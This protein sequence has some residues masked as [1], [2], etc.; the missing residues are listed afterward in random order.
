M[1]VGKYKSTPVV[2]LESLRLSASTTV[3]SSCRCWKNRWWKA[4]EDLLCLAISFF[5]NLVSVPS[6]FKTL[7]FLSSQDKSFWRTWIAARVNNWKNFIVEPIQFPFH[8][9]SSLWFNDFSCQTRSGLQIRYEGR[10]CRLSDLRVGMWSQVIRNE[11]SFYHL[12][13]MKLRRVLFNYV[14]YDKGVW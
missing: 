6:S 7:L 10:W 2:M 5:P 3:R 1:H 9:K 12:K 14:N 11:R 13:P 8:V 4:I